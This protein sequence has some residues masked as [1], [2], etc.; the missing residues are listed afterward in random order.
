MI[1]SHYLQ[2]G[3]AHFSL[4]RVLIYSLFSDHKIY[5]FMWNEFCVY[6]DEVFLG[7]TEPDIRFPP[8]Y[9]YDL[10]S[11][12]YD[13][14]SKSRV[15]SWTV[16]MISKTLHTSGKLT[17]PWLSNGFPSEPIKKHENVLTSSSQCAWI[18]YRD[19]QMASPLNQS[20][21]WNH[22]SYPITM[23]EWHAVVLY[24]SHP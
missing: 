24:I 19:S 7:F 2:N 21:T 4:E 14:S 12:T 18:R 10:N 17:L 6:L 5:I 8:T 23:L 20:K 3:K 16:S 1:L 15:P 22:I 9:K 13:S 11:D